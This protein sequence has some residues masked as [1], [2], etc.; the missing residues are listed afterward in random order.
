MTGQTTQRHRTGAEP[1]ASQSPL[2][3]IAGLGYPIR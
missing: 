2:S 1:L 3:G